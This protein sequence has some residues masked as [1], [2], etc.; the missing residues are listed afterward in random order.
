VR[1]PAASQQALEEAFSQAAGVPGV[2]SALQSAR[3]L[4]AVDYV[5]WPVSWLADRLLRHDPV[6]KVRLGTLWDELRGVSAGPAGAHEA[7]IDN[8]IT[9]LADDAGA[10]LPA[11]WPAT[12][13]GA[14]RSRVGAV[15]AELGAAIAQALPAE[16]SAVPW[17]RLVAAWQGLLLGVAAAGLAWV[18]VLIAVGVFHASRHAASLFSDVRLLPWV[19]VLVAAVLLLGWLTATGCMTL[20][21]RAAERERDQAEQTMRAGVA[22]VAQRLVVTPV[23]QELSMYARFRKELAVARA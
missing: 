20:V 22:G 3:E 9:A 2:A 17:W 23:E 19:L 11:P 21:L 8:A 16:N 12:V 13:R 7:E 10:G 14:A 18:G 15:P 5:G 4:K 1:L 6:R